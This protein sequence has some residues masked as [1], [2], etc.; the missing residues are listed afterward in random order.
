MYI[1]LRI[2][3]LS[4]TRLLTLILTAAASLV[5]STFNAAAAT[6]AATDQGPRSVRIFEAPL[7]A[8]R[9]TTLHQLVN[10]EAPA[11]IG[12]HSP[13]SIDASKFTQADVDRLTR[14]HAAVI[15]ADSTS[16]S[17]QKGGT[18]AAKPNDAP[19]PPPL[20]E[21]DCKNGV[22]S[23]GGNFYVASRYDICE[24]DRL[25]F[26]FLSGSQVVGGL[27]YDRT[28][29]GT[30]A[31]LPA[32]PARQLYFSV[33]LDNATPMGTVDPWMQFSPSWGLTNVYGPA[34]TRSGSDKTWLLS[35]LIAN[36]KVS[37]TWTY[38]VA[39]GSG[40]GVDDVY[41]DLA[42]FTFGFI[43]GPGWMCGQCNPVSTVPM[44]M[45]WDNSSYNSYASAPSGGALFPY[46]VALQYSTTGN[47]GA[48]A[49]H[50]S[51]ACS[52]PSATFPKNPAKAVPG[53]D[54]DHPLHRLNPKVDTARYKKNRSYAEDTCVAQ[55]GANYSQGQTLDCDEYPFATTY[56]GC[57]QHDYDP[58]AP[59]DNYSAMPLDKSQNR[60][61]GSQLDNFLVWNRV[62]VTQSDDGFYVTISG[63]EGPPPPPPAVDPLTVGRINGSIIQANRIDTMP[64]TYVSAE[65]ANMAS[66]HMNTLVLESSVND[67]DLQADGVPTAAYPNSRQ[68]QRST[69][70][71]VVGRLLSLADTT[72]IQVLIGLDAD[73]AWLQ[74]VNDASRTAGDANSARETADDLWQ[75][76]GSHASFG[77][78][79]LP[80]S[81]DNVH[82]GSAAAQMNLVNYYNTV[83][84]ELRAI[85]GDLT[86][87]TT[88]DFDAI[89]TTVPGWQ[90]STAYAA[91][92][93]NILPQADL[94]VVDVQDGVGEQHANAST[95]GTWF[96]AMGNAF[97]GSGAHTELYS[98]SQTYVTGSSGSTTPL[99][100]KTLVAD[101][102]A[103]KAAAYTDW[104]ASYFDYL[105]PNAGYNAQT[106]SFSKAYADWAATGTGDGG[107]GDTPPTAPT[108]VTATDVDAQS[109]TVSWTQATDPELGIAGYT[110][111][112]NGNPVATLIDNGTSMGV[113]FS[114][115]QLN[116]STAYTYKIQAFDGAGNIS[117][118][119]APVTAT[120]TATP[121]T[122]TN[123]ARCGAASGAPGCAYT[124]SYA[125]DVANYSDE[126]H[127]KLTDGV[128]GSATL[129]SAWQGRDV[130]SYSF[131]VD[132]GA[133]KDITQIRSDWLQLRQDAQWD[134]VHLPTELTFSTSTD[135]TTWNMVSTTNPPAATSPLTQ[136]NLARSPR[137]IE[138]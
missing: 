134:S 43:P 131:T 72:G 88:A 48:V 110:I 82:F 66:L 24:S 39:A 10:G 108:N 69:Q 37:T 80:L 103:T 87:A 135:G 21:A 133:V 136:T 36:G 62:L 132:L 64:D 117:A 5:V 26:Q 65:L 68:F 53:C 86:V 84:Q 52:N 123:L 129:G 19:N 99:G 34:P 60:S 38:D 47:E 83:T 17:G 32:A 29:I 118:S 35:D 104:S 125:A 90:D 107:D 115:G 96:T 59:V 126:S 124:S 91:M 25:F 63:L 16:I 46:L 56:E 2:H 76:Y 74:H 71:D 70:T 42:V 85:T 75:R 9:V 113:T 114:D 120:T 93:Q 15:S 49:K 40:V 127:T 57:A 58:N 101:I 18:A 128:T 67:D 130:G 31:G 112:R 138:G 116:G 77:G 45:R 1:R 3:P 73:D 7:T 44:A 100:V 14:Q 79:Y 13:I 33:I 94:D 28:V 95:L 105:S 12:L 27:V 50:I 106:G 111:I 54:A 23:S 6:A 121:A 78:W 51:V 8:D 109:I 89:D 102:N 30:S 137:N 22:Q 4:R 55:W 61:A 97:H 92:W 20:S 41:S 119:S 122:G 81:V 98:G 11:R